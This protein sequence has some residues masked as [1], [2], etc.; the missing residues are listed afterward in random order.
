M[1]QGRRKSEDVRRI[2]VPDAV[3][4]TEAKMLSLPWRY[5]EQLGL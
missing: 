4:D 5:I 2:D 3:V 1:S